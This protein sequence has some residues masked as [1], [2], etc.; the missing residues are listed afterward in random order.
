MAELHWKQYPYPEEN[1]FLVIGGRVEGGAVDSNTLTPF[2]IVGHSTEAVCKEWHNL[3][4][5][6]S[7]Y[8]TLSCVS[9]QQMNAFRALLDKAADD[10]S[11]FPRIPSEKIAPSGSARE[12]WLVGLSKPSEETGSGQVVMAYNIQDIEAWAEKKG[13]S[14]VSALPRSGLLATLVEMTKTQTG[15]VDNGYYAD[16]PNDVADMM[17]YA[18]SWSVEK[19]Q[20]YVE[21]FGA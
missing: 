14:L 1:V 4:G 7:N 18:K 17:K 6:K 11:G 15:E 19:R 20:K 21:L 8:A 5:R 12:P 16:G 13:M 9:M 10:P 2:I 3:T